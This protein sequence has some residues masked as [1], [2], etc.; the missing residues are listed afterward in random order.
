MAP[1]SESAVS[2]CLCDITKCEIKKIHKYI[3]HA[4]IL[5]HFVLHYIIASMKVILE[6]DQ[7]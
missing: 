5:H 4:Q 7:L 2:N 1:D 3:V 6:A